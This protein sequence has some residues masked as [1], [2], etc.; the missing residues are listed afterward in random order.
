MS[1]RD[2]LK[3]KNAL[4]EHAHHYYV[5]DDPQISDAQYD[6][7]YRDLIDIETEHPKWVE[8]DSPTQRVGAAPLDAFDS[9]PHEHPMLSLGNI[10]DA[11]ELGDFDARVKRH[12]GL[13]ESSAITYACE[14]KIDGLSIELIYRAGL[15]EIAATRG[16]GLTGENVT[17]NVKTIGSVPIRLRGKAPKALTVRGEVYYPKDKFKALNRDREAEGLPTFA[18]PRNAAA[19]SLRQL[20]PRLTA[21]RPLDAT[22]YAM[23]KP[24]KDLAG[25]ADFIVW[26][27]GLG[28]KTLD[29]EL[30]EGPEAVQKVYDRML[31]E[32]ERYPFEIDGMVIK[33]NRHDL[34][35]E[36]G[37]VSRA[38]RWAIAYKL[39]A[40]Q[41]HTRVRDISAQ[42][43]RTGAVTPVAELEPVVVG[44]VTVSRATLH[45]QD[46]VARK[47]VR[48]G[49]EVVVQRAGDVI[50]EVVK[51][52]VSKRP[53]RSKPWRFPTQCPV[54][55]T[56]LSRPEGEA[57]ARCP[58]AA[59]DA[60]VKARLQHYAS[61][62]AMDI[63]GLGQ[64][65]VE[66]L[67]DEGLVK[68]H[69]DLYTLKRDRLLEL[70]RFAEKSVDNLLAGIEKSKQQPLGRFLFGLGIRHVGEHVAKLLAKA[71]DSVESLAAADQ[72]AL[73]TV[74]GIGGEVAESVQDFFSTPYNAK[75][76][77]AL[78][79]LGVA[80]Q[81]SSPQKAS[82]I[83]NGQSVVVTGTLSTMS[84]DEAKA[85][86]ESHGGRAA[87]SVS[88]KTSFV[89]AGEAAGSKRDKAEALGVE[90]IDE[91]EFLTRLKGD[92]PTT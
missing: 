9:H 19:G 33:V 8:A 63:E 58:N 1:K 53:K 77:K 35:R 57:V 29:P 67:V 3:L 60:Q 12:L 36:L 7:L 47:D 10:F 55:T 76:V 52:V 42:V 74:H 4:L 43:G 86:I 48:V 79:K 31:S 6:R 27:Q 69:A 64:K 45:N 71:F 70:P 83:L 87:S 23:P 82:Q 44:G 40:Q 78:Q 92:E 5:L 84:R 34:Q 46:E 75:L 54:C 61:R 2:Y 68:N 66:Q 38:P 24:P 62:K 26:L 49:D 51:V 85:L 15:L 89:V 50:P 72:D 21:Q 41:E 13:E 88:K 14:P 37:E 16:D 11:T 17:S 18:N 56:P 22:F 32:R 80:P 30:A 28:F 81:S 20:D 59:C 39:P 65:V 25:H 73:L 91:N 90:I